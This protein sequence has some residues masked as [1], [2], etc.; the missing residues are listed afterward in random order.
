MDP[1]D[2]RFCGGLGFWVSHYDVAA[3]M[4]THCKARDYE[5]PDC[6]LMMRFIKYRITRRLTYKFLYPL[7]KT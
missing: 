7:K 5:F 1:A 6:V 4:T 3:N 2:E